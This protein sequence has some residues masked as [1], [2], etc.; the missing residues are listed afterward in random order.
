MPSGISFESTKNQLQRVITSVGLEPLQKKLGKLV[1]LAASGLMYE[2]GR[3]KR[4]YSLDPNVRRL[5]QLFD[6]YF[7]E[8]L[9]PESPAIAK[10]KARLI[11]LSF[12]TNEQAVEEFNRNQESLEALSLLHKDREELEVSPE[13]F[14]ALIE[15]KVKYQDENFDAIIDYMISL[16]GRENEA[17]KEEIAH[18]VEEKA[19]PLQKEVDQLR[20]EGKNDE[21]DEKQLQI[22]EIRA[23]A[24][25]IRERETLA[26][27]GREATEGLPAVVGELEKRRHL[28]EALKEAHQ[29]KATVQ[30]AASR[31]GKDEM[32]QFVV[33]TANLLSTEVRRKEA[34]EH[35][36]YMGQTGSKS[37]GLNGI[38]DLP[39]VE[40]NIPPFVRELLEDGPEEIGAMAKKEIVKQIGPMLTNLLGNERIREMQRLHRQENPGEPPL[41]A[42]ALF[43][44]FTGQ[45]FTGSLRNVLNKQLPEAFTEEVILSLQE[46]AREL[47]CGVRREIPEGEE[48]KA[49][50]KLYDKIASKGFEEVIE[51]AIGESF[52]KIRD[53]LTDA[54]DQFFASITQ[55][56]PSCV[57]TGLTAQGILPNVEVP[58][59]VD[60]VKNP[61]G[62]T[63]TVKF[64][65]N[66]LGT[67]ALPEVMINENAG[68]VVPLIFENV[69]AEKL[70]QDFFRFLVDYQYGPKYKEGV[71]SYLI[72]DILSGLQEHLGKAKVADSMPEIV[73]H[74]VIK[75]RGTLSLAQIYLFSQQDRDISVFH[76]EQSFDVTLHAF[77]DFW[78]VHGT[79]ETLRKDFLLR[80]R[81][82]RA[83]NRIADEAVMLS[84]DNAI[85]AAKLRQVYATIWEAEKELHEAEKRKVQD[86]FRGGI[87]IPAGMQSH[88]KAVLL[89]T[90]ADPTFLEVLK[91]TFLA[92]AGNDCEP[93]FDAALEEVLPEVVSSK[94][95]AEA[96]VLDWSEIFQVETVRKK[97]DALKMNRLS[98]LQLVKFYSKMLVIMLVVLRVTLSAKAIAQTIDR[99]LPTVKKHLPF[100][101]YY[102][103]LALT[104][105]GPQFFAK[106]LPKDAYESIAA[107]YHLVTDASWYLVRR[108]LTIGF[109]EAIKMGLPQSEKDRIRS[110]AKDFQQKILRQG[111]Y[112]YE[113]APSQ[114]SH[115]RVTLDPA[116]VSIPDSILAVEETPLFDE[117]TPKPDKVKL[118][119]E[120]YRQE[121]ARWI[122]NAS[123]LKEKFGT[124]EN[125]HLIYLNEQIRNIP[126]F[127]EEGT[128][129]DGVLGASNQKVD[130]AK[131][132]KELFL[133]DLNSVKETDFE[134]VIDTLKRIS[135]ASHNLIT[136]LNRL[137]EAKTI[138][139]KLDTAKKPKRAE[140]AFEKK[141]GQVEALRE[142]ALEELHALKSAGKREAH[143]AKQQAVNEALESMHSLML[144]LYQ[145]SNVDSDK[146]LVLA[147]KVEEMLQKPAD[148][149]LEELERILPEITHYLPQSDLAHLF[150]HCISVKRLEDEVVDEL[151]R[152]RKR[153]VSLNREHIKR[154]LFTYVMEQK[155]DNLVEFRSSTELESKVNVLKAKMVEV[156]ALKES[157][158]EDLKKL[159]RQSTSSEQRI[160]TV[161]SFY[162]LYAAIDL[163]AKES[164]NSG[165]NDFHHPA[166]GA[167]LCRFVQKPGLKVAHERSLRQLR[168]LCNYFGFE[169]GER[170]SEDAIQRKFAYNH[171][172][173]DGLGTWLTGRAF[174]GGK[175]G[176]SLTMNPWQAYW[177][178]EKSYFQD[179]LMREDIQDR[180]AAHG[181]SSKASFSEK[182]MMLFRD[183]ALSEAR[184]PGHKDLENKYFAGDR[185][186][187][188]LPREYYL[189]RLAHLMSTSRTLFDKGFKND[190]FFG[191]DGKDLDAAQERGL[192]IDV[193]YE[194]AQ[195][196]RTIYEKATAFLT[197][198]R[199]TVTRG[200]FVP[201]KLSA[202]LGVLTHEAQRMEAIRDRTLG[203]QLS[204]TDTEYTVG[205]S[206]RAQERYTEESEFEERRVDQTAVIQSIR[207]AETDSLFTVEEKRLLEMVQS[208]DKNRL[209]RAL[210]LFSYRK[211]RLRSPEMRLLFDMLCQNLVAM[212]AQAKERAEVGKAV[213]KF[214]SDTINHMVRIG[215]LE[216]AL[217]MIRMGVEMEGFFISHDPQLAQSF[218]DF[219]FTI[220]EEII[221]AYKAMPKDDQG[222]NFGQ[223][224]RVNGVYLAV[225]TLATVYMNIDIDR[226]EESDRKEALR[227]IA[228][229]AFFQ[230][231]QNAEF[232]TQPVFREAKRVAFTNANALRELFT[233]E[234]EGI[235][236]GLEMDFE[237]W[238]FEASSDE[239]SPLLD[240]IFS[241][242]GIAIPEGEWTGNFPKFKKEGGE[243]RV[244]LS[245]KVVDGHIR[246]YLQ[247]KAEEE[248]RRVFQKEDLGP[249]QVLEGG[250][251]RYDAVDATI[252]WSGRDCRFIIFR[253]IDGARSQYID[254]TSISIGWSYSPFEFKPN[255]L[256][257]MNQDS[258]Q[259]FREGVHIAKFS[260]HMDG[261]GRK[262]E[263]V[264]REHFIDGEWHQG[265]DLS[266]QKHRITLLDWLITLD[267]VE[268]FSQR[269]S[270]DDEGNPRPD[271]ITHFRLKGIGLE[272][273][274]R[275][276]EEGKLE[277]VSQA[278]ATKGYVLCMPEVG[279]NRLYNY[280]H[281]I[282]LRSETGDEKVVMKSMPLI[283]M[284]MKFSINKV[285][286]TKTSPMVDQLINEGMYGLYKK[287]IFGIAREGVEAV[288][289]EDNA[290]LR[291][292]GSAYGAI[293][294]DGYERMFWDD[295]QYFTST[296]DS[297]G[298]LT[299]RDPNLLTYLTLYHYGSG[300][301]EL[302]MEY[303]EKL[304]TYGKE[305]PFTEEALNYIDRLILFLGED[306]QSPLAT[307]LCLR[308]A[309]IR[310]KNYLIHMPTE[311]SDE[312]KRKA[313]RLEIIRS[314]VLQDRMC[315]YL[316]S[317]KIGGRK[318]LSLEDELFILKTI[319]RAQ[320]DLFD[321]LTEGRVD[322]KKWKEKVRKSLGGYVGE[323]FLRRKIVDRL[324]YLRAK[325]EKSEIWKSRNIRFLWEAIWYDR[326]NPYTRFLTQTQRDQSLGQMNSRLKDIA[327]TPLVRPQDFDFAG[328]M[329]LEG[330]LED[331]PLDPTQ[332]RPTH[333]LSEFVHYYHLAANQL[334]TGWKGREALFRKKREQFLAMLPK[335]K[336]NFAPKYGICFEILE[337]VASQGGARWVTKK[338]IGDIPKA[339]VLKV[340][341]IAI[342]QGEAGLRAHL[343]TL[344]AQDEEERKLVEL[345]LTK[346]YDNLRADVQHAEEQLV[347]AKQDV[348]RN[349]RDLNEDLLTLRDRDASKER[350]S[351]KEIQI[352][353][354]KR[355]SEI[356]IRDVEK[357]LEKAENALRSEFN[358][359]MKQLIKL[360]RGDSVAD[361]A[362]N[363]LTI[364]NLAG[365]GKGMVKAGLFFTAKPIKVI[366]QQVVM[367]LNTRMSERLKKMA[368]SAS[369]V[370]FT[371]QAVRG[372]SNVLAEEWRIMN[373]NED[374]TREPEKVGEDLAA[375]LRQKEEGLTEAL[376][377]LVEEYFEVV[378]T[379]IPPKDP[380]PR[381]NPA[382]Y[383]NEEELREGFEAFNHALDEYDARNPGEEIELTLK[384]GRSQEEFYYAVRTLQ[385]ETLA[386]FKSE[387]EKILEFVNQEKLRD[388][389]ERGRTLKRLDKVHARHE[390]IEFFDIMRWFLKDD[391]GI[392]LNRSETRAEDLPE[393]SKMVYSYLVSVSRFNLIFKQLKG[394]SSSDEM[395]PLVKEL[396]RERNYEFDANHEERLLKAKIAYEAFRGVILWETQAAHIDHIGRTSKG[397]N[398]LNVMIMGDGKSSTVIPGTD[399][400]AAD[401]KTAFVVNIWPKSVKGQSLEMM[402]KYGLGVYK[403]GVNAIAVDRQRNW[404]SERLWALAKV[405]K[406]VMQNKEQMNMTQEDAQGLLLRFQEEVLDVDEVFRADTSEYYK[407]I[408]RYK[409]VLEVFMDH[410]IGNIDEIHEALREDKE[411][412]FPLGKRRTLRLEFAEALE[413]VMLQLLT[414]DEVRPYIHIKD[415]EPK[416]LDAGVFNEQ[417]APVIA[418]KLVALQS[419]E[420]PDEERETVAAYLCGRSEEIPLFVVKH[421]QFKKIA[422]LR[423]TLMVI[424]PKT[425]ERI[426]HKH[427]NKTETTVKK[428][429]P[430]QSGK[431]REEQQ[432]YAKPSEGNDNTVEEADFLSPLETFFKTLCI[433]AKDRLS[434]EEVLMMISY[435]QNESEGEAKKLGKRREN[436]PIAEFFRDQICPAIVVD[437]VVQR[438]AV[439]LWSLKVA[440]DPTTG[441]VDL[442]R[443][444]NISPDVIEQVRANDMVT[445]AF[446][447]AYIRHQIRYS[448]KILESN[449]QDLI[450]MF[451]VTRNHTGTPEEELLPEGTKTVAR[452]GILGQSIHTFETRSKEVRVFEESNPL[453]IL[454]RDIIHGFFNQSS[455]HMHVIDRG[456]ALNGISNKEVA[457]KIWAGIQGVRLD[458][459]GVVF[460]EK[461]QHG[462]HIAK[463]LTKNGI[464]LLSE[465]RLSPAERLTYYDESHTYAADVPQK[466]GAVGLL[467][468]GETTTFEKEADQAQYRARG[469]ETK[470][471]EQII[472]M[473][474]HVRTKVIDEDSVPTIREVTVFMRTNGIKAKKERKYFIKLR[475]LQGLVKKAILRNAVKAPSAKATIKALRAHS[476][477]LVTDVTDDPVQLFAYMKITKNQT[478]ALKKV[479]ED[480]IKQLREAGVLSGQEIEQVKT[481]LTVVIE[482][483]RFIAGRELYHT[484]QNKVTE[485]LNAAENKGPLTEKFD[486]F[487]RLNVDVTLM[488]FFDTPAGQQADAVQTL[489]KH[490]LHWVRNEFFTERE[491]QNLS[492][493]LDA[494]A[495][496]APPPTTDTIDGFDTSKGLSVEA[497]AAMGRQVQV[498]AQAEAE[499]EQE[500]EQ[501][502]EVDNLQ[503][504]GVAREY[505]VQPD[506]DISWSEML[507][508]TNLKQ[509]FK[510]MD[511]A[512]GFKSLS[513]FRDYTPPLFQLGRGLKLASSDAVQEFADTVSPAIACS[514]NMFKVF[515]SGFRSRIVEPFG[516]KQ[517]PIQE[518]LLIQDEVGKQTIL[519]IDH[520]EVEFWRQKLKED[521]VDKIIPMDAIMNKEVRFAYKA[522]S[523]VKLALIDN[524]TGAILATGRNAMTDDE[525]NTRTVRMARVQMKVMSG[526]TSY[527]REKYFDSAGLER[528]SEQELLES[529]VRSKGIDKV[530]NFFQPVAYRDHV[531]EEIEQSDIQALFFK[532]KNRA[533]EPQM[534]RI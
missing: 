206:K 27:S 431:V 510:L 32:E 479:C 91:E 337:R 182:M 358:E 214:F 379:P 70:N 244:D 326:S 461:D 39:F 260:L 455:N 22:D 228:R 313:K 276:N 227:D 205:A 184:G 451:K 428:K 468:V 204:G 410:G 351:Q 96:E 481:D 386:T 263:V 371:E 20:A 528:P 101:T 57:L 60:I 9:F 193:S 467:T 137:K 213:G 62:R 185:R 256:V 317:I 514:W 378:R 336:G 136:I 493:E 393:L 373:E 110:V 202:N 183:P 477:I 11:D 403:Q 153:G 357:H 124:E 475:K 382:D 55:N 54:T 368:F 100:S 482:G 47:F 84:N 381:F 502:E 12:A 272:F 349:V 77:L 361:L 247:E 274:V 360:S 3:A 420:I 280:P 299:E 409:E 17:R 142:T 125:Y 465:S 222:V 366:G 6:K 370:P 23:R 427:F 377:E 232:K 401:G 456:A 314:L 266:K 400:E 166:N 346:N 435:L 450:N 174:S 470:G 24:A 497:A 48:P 38:L 30:E 219:A 105:F 323:I 211:D 80:E 301:L 418:Q 293:L 120:N 113:V 33:D 99:R 128:F 218:P 239:I 88:I 8:G 404:D 82:R 45:L 305:Y 146:R 396:L 220:R 372:V 341:L 433:Y 252:R 64:Y 392:L 298:L 42:L 141:M 224:Q 170:Y 188:I 478:E 338:F 279:D 414:T 303:F 364:S 384:E 103:G 44:K 374:L 333:L 108:V 93:I 134:E 76:S 353:E 83:I 199:D 7:P 315:R 245:R 158:F 104:L 496:T 258:I 10:L 243:I 215:D 126:V 394:L 69:S 512:A 226:L 26:R 352:Q 262:I 312:D 168:D 385:R 121:F 300:R 365:I 81:M 138:Q 95:V 190:C 289:K 154:N 324:H 485:K 277:A 28:G 61:D 75:T 296:I 419:L 453:D 71:H 196:P 335:I 517:K 37:V 422:L 446:V 474:R 173:F 494:I 254:P 438:P 306:Q 221:P 531:K 284:L 123:K 140:A 499:E 246:S 18:R 348:E 150:S 316:D 519:I 21:A 407:R 109:K 132:I 304:E 19:V 328:G 143:E 294:F 527:S 73:P 210:T 490:A 503:E 31:V 397:Q 59:W 231:R 1:R 89:E 25:R 41:D 248:L 161:I 67:D 523:K 278:G 526:F 534:I 162:S 389:D 253:E 283:T 425:L 355:K 387:R 106:V 238:D 139:D 369:P 463:I 86:D 488:R 522:P 50:E 460:F 257:F 469:L 412:N 233:R 413:E 447:R 144:A 212:E 271:R 350:I 40:G 135:P 408:D 201:V 521:R 65:T 235:L 471:Q 322:G 291:A 491:Y 97:I 525:A 295:P 177:G 411:L 46:D 286:R 4:V 511:P 533:R 186:K 230:G 197:S 444:L 288:K 107:L 156:E 439:D 92:A 147:E 520:K 58:Y 508:P 94:S 281:A 66:A 424:A 155:I 90:G 2:L 429:D 334:P 53:N 98:L 363:V 441:K 492:E 458:I 388:D 270:D 209:F 203:K 163:L 327:G 171:F 342:N 484:V 275:E 180:L 329:S 148:L 356:R 117:G 68:I 160:E 178:A 273:K 339:I 480:Y 207:S 79:F 417:V 395:E 302:A 483:K 487:L 13:V 380:R 516:V 43:E 102:A 343:D 122:E 448:P 359:S 16:C 265:V 35:F 330:S 208:Y 486:R 406:A 332:V 518:F 421:P 297:D 251:F 167:N 5:K 331:V 440:T 434:D 423:G 175:D 466:D 452:S 344:I 362:S 111:D 309:A 340:Q 515:T 524:M 149:S 172:N 325:C 115:D 495:A 127:A 223:S 472:A 78:R 250:V 405:I 200:A 432:R 255:D 442:R 63:Y 85:S 216:T 116:H 506:K 430:S 159:E 489:K 416:K 529:W 437:G 367:P 513:Y 464:S 532:L 383:G 169:L 530:M 436:T 164:E 234:E 118:T 505:D 198:V 454:D 133:C 176:Q 318:Y 195:V 449:G 457:Q 459:K 189:L 187:G 307:E 473:T 157:A 354:Y 192:V 165:L 287:Y 264:K 320:Q 398:L 292:M 249:C 321:T 310:E 269:Q 476:N 236:F 87:V 498:Q 52:V 74:D 56:L 415:R 36:L 308:L 311:K 225:A 241:D 145:N 14:E 152:N 151:F 390:P 15:G 72:E 237:S 49:A 242:A 501:M 240:E 445:C 130:L 509:W 181:V 500:Q 34:G 375:Q 462:I 217:Y 114:G 261:R 179:L 345:T 376:N 504:A 131:K 426:I 285:G 268:A 290:V 194:R 29:T 229:F 399:Y 319:V 112:E 402:E 443:S 191:A 391:D 119:A 282:L 259:V 267:D 129:W 347:Q 507:E 51:R